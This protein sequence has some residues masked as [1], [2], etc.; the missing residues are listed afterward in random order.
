MSYR[1]PEYVERYEDAVFE[2]ETP[3][4]TQ[5]A[6][7]AGEVSLFDWY[8]A[9]FLVNFK[10]EKLADGSNIAANDHN[11]LVNGIHSLIKNLTVQINGIQVYDNTN[12]NQTTNNKTS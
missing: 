10:V 11:G 1:N 9:S 2:L 6:N 12:A 4:V 5:V 7:N 8:N 3:L